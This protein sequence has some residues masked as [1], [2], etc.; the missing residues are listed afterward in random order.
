M[1]LGVLQCVAVCCSVSSKSPNWP[2]VA[3]QCSP[4]IHVTHQYATMRVVACVAACVTVCCSVFCSVMQTLYSY[5][6]YQC[7]T[8][9][10]VACVAVCG[11]VCVAVFCSV[12]QPLYS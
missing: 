10:V 8:M 9:C 2:L 12:M 6:T 7:A 1:A 11:S 5:H 4:C 3:M